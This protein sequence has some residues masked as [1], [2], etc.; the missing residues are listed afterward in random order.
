MLILLYAEART[1]FIAPFALGALAIVLSGVGLHLGGW[2]FGPAPAVLG[3]MLAYPCG[4]GAGWS[5]P[6]LP[7]C[8]ADRPRA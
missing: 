7:G 3:C 8:R 2:W 5:L 1:G 4:A 6:A